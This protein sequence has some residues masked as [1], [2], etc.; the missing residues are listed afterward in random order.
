MKNLLLIT[1]LLMPF[2][3]FSQSQKPIDGF[4]GIKFGA[5]ILQVKTAMKAKGA[6]FDEKNSKPELLLFD[7]VSLGKRK[8]DLFA[9]RFLDGKVYSALFIFKPELEART[10]D[11]YDDLQSSIND[12][13]GKG[14]ANKKFKS[15][16]EDG[17]GYEI[18]AIKTGNADYSTFWHDDKDN[19][20]GETISDELEITLVYQDS[21]MGEIAE[22][23]QKEK[24]KAE[25]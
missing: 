21:A 1:M 25:F 16:Y 20:I 18:S 24:E 9:L 10:I 15:P 19:T 5:T 12:V 7:N 13:Y 11:F 4:L 3:G 22:K 6:T 8:T 2:I 17:D 14:K 23:R